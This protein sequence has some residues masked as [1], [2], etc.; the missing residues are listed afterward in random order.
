VAIPDPKM[1]VRWQQRFS[2]F[3]KALAQ[4]R[5]FV[6]QDV[7]N[8]LESLGLIQCFE[9][10]HELAWKTLKDFLESKGNASLFGS[11]DV[12]RAAFSLELIA[13]G[14]SWMAMIVDRNR[15]SH[16]YNSE[17]AQAIVSNIKGIYFQLF[18]SLE[19]KLKSLDDGL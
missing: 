15:T 10:T 5:K 7:L 13:D 9:Y 17:T 12:T 1:D 14:E 19:T 6:A 3:G 16:T 2:N 8:E 4:L 18:E 11:R